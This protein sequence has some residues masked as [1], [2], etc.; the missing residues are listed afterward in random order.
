MLFNRA[1]CIESLKSE[2][3]G[4]VKALLP[5]ILIAT[6]LLFASVQPAHAN[7]FVSLSAGGVTDS[8]NNSLAVTSTNC[9]SGF[10]LSIPNTITF[11][12]T[13]D[14]YTVT[15]FSLSSNQ[16][17]TLG[18]VADAVFFV[19]HTS[20]SSSDMLTVDF[21]TFNMT[22]PVG[23]MAL[24]GTQTVNWNQSVATDNQTFQVW[25]Q[26]NNSLSG[27]VTTSPA[28][29]TCTAGAAPPTNGCTKSAS[30][31]TFTNTGQY[32][33]NAAEVIS[34]AV[35][36]TANYTGTVDATAVPEPAT[37]LLLGLSLSGFALVSRRKRAK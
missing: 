17:P 23:P 32:A 7:L 35:G 10:S 9:G 3:R 11:T 12:G 13:V 33:L 30:G 37:F 36:D 29:T 26:S 18:D 25:G 24:S 1:S 20:G 4:M 27:G 16:S 8:C 22:Q 2:N 15:T 14:G 19:Q 28:V 6:V 34:E 21:S 5:G 31:A